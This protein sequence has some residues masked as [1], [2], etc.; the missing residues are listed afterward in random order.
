[1]V[2]SPKIIVVDSPKIEADSPKIIIVVDSPKI[3]VVDSPKI[4]V[5]NSRKI[6]VADSP[7]ILVAD[8]SKNRLFRNLN[9]LGQPYR[10][11]IQKEDV[12]GKCQNKYFINEVNQLCKCHPGMSHISMTHTRIF[13]TNQKPE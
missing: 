4:L 1:M 10:N 5:A 12:N 9:F 6:S 13:L 8:S 11:C 3:I 2:D 7:K